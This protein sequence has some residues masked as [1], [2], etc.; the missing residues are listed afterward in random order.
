MIMWVSAREQQRDEWR[1]QKRASR[2]S[3]RAWPALTSNMPTQS[4]P[5]SA[6]TPAHTGNG[7]QRFNGGAANCRCWRCQ[8][9]AATRADCAGVSERVGRFR[10]LR[11]DLP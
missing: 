6:A 11:Y 10:A 4:L 8:R 1:A 3:P 9:E 7:P 2:K 5:H